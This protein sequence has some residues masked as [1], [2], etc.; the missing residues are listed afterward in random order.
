MPKAC[1]KL[2]P[3]ELDHDVWRMFA[4]EG[5][6]REAIAERLGKSQAC[7]DYHIAEGKR[8]IGIDVAKAKEDSQRFMIPFAFQ[9]LQLIAKTFA[10]QNPK[11]VDA[12]IKF[13][14]NAGYTI[15]TQELNVNHKDT[16]SPDQSFESVMQRFKSR[17]VDASTIEEKQAENSDQ[18][19]G[20]S[21]PGQ[22]GINA[23]ATD[24]LESTSDQ[25]GSTPTSISKSSD[26][27]LPLSQSQVENP[28]SDQESPRSDIPLKP[29]SRDEDY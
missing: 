12:A 11:Y 18:S 19:S 20:E 6:S 21:Q 17:A 5:R 28:K 25:Q 15:E 26:S 13:L 1:N 14:R 10:T 24:Q 9:G 3:S 23:P 8:L 7:I 27:I 16:S 22:P 29:M 4:L 2:A